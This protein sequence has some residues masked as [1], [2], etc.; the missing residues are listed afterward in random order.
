[1]WMLAISFLLLAVACSSSDDTEGTEAQQTMLSVYVYSPEHPLLIRSDV[2]QVSPTL[3]ES[4]V[5]KLQIWVFESE[6]GTLVGY[7][8]TKEGETALLNV[9]EGAVYQLPV[10]DDFVRRKPQVDVYVLANVDDS[11]CGVTLTG[12]STRA[13]INTAYLNENY[14]GL[15][16]LVTSI[17]ADGLPMSGVLKN[18]DVVGEAPVLRVGTSSIATVKVTRAVSKVRFVF[19][20]T[21]GA[22]T[23]KIKRITLD[24]EVHPTSEYLIPRTETLLYNPTEATLWSGEETAVEKDNPEDYVY[25][26]QTAQEYETLI[27]QS[28]LTQMGPFYL[29][30]SDRRLTGVITYTIGD[31]V[32]HTRAF[33]MAN[34]GDFLR[35]HT[36][37]VYAYHQGGGYLLLDAVYVKDWNFLNEDVDHAIY[38]W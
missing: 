29:R 14:F 27:D 19:A 25:H 16:S 36:W 32:E 15:A 1:M 23:L 7:L 9:S 34:A 6:S 4:K 11:N 2:G 21:T 3:D 28:G 26:T 18:Q 33:Q 17:P 37:I 22:S 24:E 20:N 30:E 8:E 35:N 5:N 38:N 13:A 31:G 12:S 10:T